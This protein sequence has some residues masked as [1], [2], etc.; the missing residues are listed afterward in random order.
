MSNSSVDVRTGDDGSV[1][2]QPHGTVGADCAVE[3]R[4]VLVH[5][6]RRLRPHRLVLDLGD[7]VELDSINLGTVAAI[8]DLGADHQV[9]VFVV[10]ATDAIGA[11][12][13]DAGVAPRHLWGT[14]PKIR[15]GL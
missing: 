4:Q 14:S 12:L 9:A 10:G 5:V 2:L 15:A 8:C 11:R 7:V 3:L 1:I 13:L 6:I